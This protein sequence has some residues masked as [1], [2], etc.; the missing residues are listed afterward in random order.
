[1]IVIYSKLFNGSALDDVESQLIT[2]LVVDVNRVRTNSVM[3]EDSVLNL[4]R[5]N[6][7]NDYIEKEEVSTEIIYPLW[8]NVLYKKGWVYTESLDFLKN[9]ILVKY[10]PIKRLTEE[11][12]EIID[13]VTT[14]SESFVIN[15]DLWH[16]QNNSTDTSCCKVFDKL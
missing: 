13:H 10:S 9:D 12:R 1:M 14:S 11:Q 16:R 2:Y 5:G 8:K 3:Y 7:V 6:S 15:G 4:T